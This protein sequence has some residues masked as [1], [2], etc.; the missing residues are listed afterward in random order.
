MQPQDAIAILG[1]G[2]AAGALAL[3]LRWRVALQATRREAEASRRAT[4]S[5][6]AEARQREGLLRAVVE[7]TPVAI[8]LFADEGQIVFTNHAARELFFD[9][10]S[11]EGQNF[12][13][14]LDRAPAPLRCALQAD[15][16]D[17]VTVEKEGEAET[18][19]VS[20]RTLEAEGRPHVLVAVRPVTQ[21]VA[22]QEIATLKRV[23]RIIGHEAGNSLGPIVSLM[24][25]ARVLL[26]QA[27][28]TRRLEPIFATVEE[29]A[30]HLEK[31]L[32]AYGELARLPPLALTMVEWGPFLEGLRGLW[33]TIQLGAP[34]AVPGWF[35]RAQIQQVVINLV[36]NA[37]ETGSPHDEVRLEVHGPEEGGVRIVVLDRGPGMSEEVMRNAL[38]P[39]F[40]T[41]PSGS[42]LGLAICREIVEKHRGRMRLAR[43]ADGGMAIS[44]WLPDR[45]LQ[46]AR[47]GVETRIRLGL[48][49][50]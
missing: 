12:F 13:T 4:A 37:L 6:A 28:E 44:F 41:K 19:Y 9:G 45:D 16:D 50:S 32:S 21:P 38:L 7:T 17:L 40:S 39:F 2:A 25:S 18:F 47:V 22:R 43:R 29:R 1:A 24:G 5:A 11:V 15:E 35:D 20:K 48:T 36:K 26:A 42:G 10:T 27:G 3:A 8:L 23:I 30:R 14:M 46:A 34:P 33:P 31:F 49:R